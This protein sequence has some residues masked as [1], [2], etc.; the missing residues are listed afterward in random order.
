ME[1]ETHNGSNDEGEHPELVIWVWL[2]DVRSE[3]VHLEAAHRA[4][5]EH[6]EPGRE[7]QREHER[8]ARAR[9]RAHEREDRED[10]REERR[11]DRRE[12][13]ALPE[14]RGDEEGPAGE[15]QAEQEV[16][17]DDE[18]DVRRGE[19]AEVPYDGDDD[20]CREVR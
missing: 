13:R 4:D 16:H 14:R 8:R 1:A 7:Q 19:D 20:P 10:D 6:V 5:D 9:A 17:G 3:L 18:P 11:R 15:R 12:L 2:H